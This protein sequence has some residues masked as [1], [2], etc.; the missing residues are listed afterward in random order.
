MKQMKKIIALVLCAM[1]L[2]AFA[3]C[4]KKADK[5]GKNNGK[6]VLDS[7]EL[8][9]DVDLSKDVTLGD[10]KL[11][12]DPNVVENGDVANIDY[13][14]K[15][16]GV[17][18]EGGTAQGFDLTIGSGQFIPGF[19][20][21][22]VGKKVGETVDLDLTFPE[23]YDSEELAGAKVVF[24]VTV[25]SLKKGLIAKVVD[26]AKVNN[27]PTG[28]NVD[29]TSAMVVL[30]AMYKSTQGASL[31]DLLAANGQKLNDFVAAAKQQ[32]E[33]AIPELLKEAKNEAALWSAVDRMLVCY[34][35]FQK[36][37]LSY[38][39]AA[40]KD[41]TGYERYYKESEL[42]EEA[43]TKYLEETAEKK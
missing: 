15:K 18:F 32:Q 34:T 23:N 22:L 28:D 33:D 30:N 35:Y 38:D 20:D 24:T 8:F 3:G 19:E 42:V 4:G 31:E 6:P 2:F 1:L 12:I 9:K 25:N 39:A 36:N 21:G 14:G 5:D 17:A 37:G 27:Y 26:V 16:D 41:L 13:C 43:V 29:V 40:L 10:V 11:E 7:T